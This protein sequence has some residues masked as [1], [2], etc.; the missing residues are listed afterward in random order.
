MF[1]RAAARM[2]A[3]DRGLRDLALGVE[4]STPAHDRIRERVEPLARRLIERA[5]AEG[6]LRPDVTVE[7]VP[8]VL[9]MI[10]ELAHRSHQVRPDLYD[11]YL[12]L[13]I[14]GL[15]RSDDAGDLGRP[16]SPDDVDAL[17]RAWLPTAQSRR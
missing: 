4:F 1:L 13:L 8:L 15:R 3:A 17:A 14:D 12:H 7:D 9:M 2:Q 5:Q 10:T 16:P 6:S 11:R